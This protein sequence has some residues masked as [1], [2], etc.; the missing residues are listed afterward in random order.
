MDENAIGSLTGGVIVLDGSN[1]FGTIVGND[2]K[3]VRGDEGIN[4]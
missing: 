4:K 2:T 1:G 3:S